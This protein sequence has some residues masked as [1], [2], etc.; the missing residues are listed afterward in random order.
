MP[1][2]VKLFSSG[3]LLSGSL[4]VLGGCC[5]PESIEVSVFRADGDCQMDINYEGTALGIYVIEPQYFEVKK[6]KQTDAVLDVQVKDVKLPRSNAEFPGIVFFGLD[7]TTFPDGIV[8][9][10]RYGDTEKDRA[11][12]T[13]N[14]FMH[15]DRAEY[16]RL[17]DEATKMDLGMS[18]YA[19]VY[20][21]PLES[22][23]TGCTHC[24]LSSADAERT[25]GPFKIGV[26]TVPGNTELK[27]PGDEETSSFVCPAAGD[28]DTI[29]FG[30]P[31]SPH[32][33]VD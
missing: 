26:V 16:N 15:S 17:Y 11:I 25:V 29:I 3:L 27:I 28:S 9:P 1:L 18:K 14:A 31:L 21:M 6:D 12:D 20:P 13:K 4:F 8:P 24:E 10:V 30:T 2:S 32:R 7:T 5:P 23:N 22:A 19:L 33:G